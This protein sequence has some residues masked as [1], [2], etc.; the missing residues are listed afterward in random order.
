MPEKPEPFEM[1]YRAKWNVPQAAEALGFPACEQS[2]TWVKQ[3]FKDWC[4][5]NRPDYKE[6]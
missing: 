6:I 1:L 3:A 4:I 5:T 2:W